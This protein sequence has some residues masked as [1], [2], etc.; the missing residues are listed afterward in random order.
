MYK[1]KE[2]LNF[3]VS[4]TIM[5]LVINADGSLNDKQKTIIYTI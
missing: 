4:P 5:N 1:K 2:N 3:G